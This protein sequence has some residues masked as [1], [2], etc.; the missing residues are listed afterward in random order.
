MSHQGTRNEK[1]TRVRREGMTLLEMMIAIAIFAI[2]L[3]CIFPLVDQMMCRIQMARDH[4]VSASIS[5]ARIER[6][7]GAQ[8]QDLILMGEKAA[9][10]DDYG[11]LTPEGRF[12]RT[13]TVVLDSPVEG[14]THMT[15]DTRICLCSR[16]GWR[17]TLH[18]K[19]TGKF[20]CRFTEEH[21]QMNFLF[22]EYKE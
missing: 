18:P 4:L 22:T 21:E 14:M 16:W 3:A 7:R 12:E 15:V 17:R 1:M 9:I 11:N 6:A 13:T 5:Q 19:K 10:V 8:Y 20:L 2:V